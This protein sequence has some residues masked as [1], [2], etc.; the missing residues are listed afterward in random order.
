MRTSIKA[1]QGTFVSSKS[2]KTRPKSKGILPKLINGNKGSQMVTQEHHSNF[3]IS[4][5]QTNFGS[6]IEE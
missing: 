2:N 5:Y 1:N 4:K 3:D 6:V